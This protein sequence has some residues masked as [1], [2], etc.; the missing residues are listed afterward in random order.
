[1]P[2]MLVSR[3]K[4]LVYA[5]AAAAFLAMLVLWVGTPTDQPIRALA[6]DPTPASA[7]MVVSPA[8]APEP[9]PATAPEATAAIAMS[10]EA[11]TAVDVSEEASGMETAAFLN[12]APALPEPEPTVATAPQVTATNAPAPTSTPQ[13]KAQPEFRV[14]GIIYTARPAAIVNRK[15]VYLGDQVN[16]ATVVGIYRTHVT[17][18]INGQRKTFVLR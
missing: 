15:T 1:M 11:T 13:E 14:N 5:V 2:V 12:P 4:R 10:E 9:A 3:R 17:L 18:Q 7:P 6:P 8:P 16:G